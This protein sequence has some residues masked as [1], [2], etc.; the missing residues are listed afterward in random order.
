MPG[1][2]IRGSA[3]FLRKSRQ[4]LG[5]MRGLRSA[6]IWYLSHRRHPERL[7]NRISFVMYHGVQASARKTLASQLHYMR[8][9][10]EFIST[11]QAIEL[12]QRGDKI[13]GRYFSI[14]FDDGEYGAF[15]NG[16]TTLAEEGIPGTFF[17]VPAW[18]STDAAMDTP[19][20]KYV[21]WDECRQIAENGGI[22]G[23]HTYSHSR[24]SMLAEH[25]STDE[26]IT[27]KAV[28]ERKL[29]STCDQFACPW[30][31]PGEDYLA[32]RDPNLAAEAG[33]R[34]FFTTIRGSAV[35]GTSHWAIPR[36]RLEPEW[37]QHQLRY[38]LCR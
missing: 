4:R 5:E 16:F 18:V 9:L 2:L 20:R 31:Q 8:N 21:S 1:H 17:I 38:L 23:S 11:T 27:S 25:E 22:I 10:G 19:G 30:G 13:D 35:Q 32:E 24:L 7:E 6:A 12:L 14:T 28:L 33:Y 36:I 37:G 15:A 26:M 34:S 29:G 3:A